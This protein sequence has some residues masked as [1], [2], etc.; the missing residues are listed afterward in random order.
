MSYN[1]EINFNDLKTKLDQSKYIYKNNVVDSQ[2]FI[3]ELILK[4]KSNNLKVI[5]RIKNCAQGN[6]LSSNDNI[7][8]NSIN[9]YKLTI[10]DVNYPKKIIIVKEL[11]NH[12]IETNTYK[13]NNIHIEISQTHNN[14]MAI[15]YNINN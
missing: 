7:I 8:Y 1:Y 3:F 13:K 5:R 2:I 14:L 4:D 11:L 10:F 12:T 9:K 6:L 15:N